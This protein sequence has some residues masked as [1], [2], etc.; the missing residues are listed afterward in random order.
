MLKKIN[1]LCYTSYRGGYMD[2]DIRVISTEEELKIFSDPYRL[3]IINVFQ[4]NSKPLTV[5]GCA[6]IM[7]EVP[8]KVYY[9][10]KKLLKIHILEL[11]H[12]EI[13]NGINAKY[14]KLI[15]RKFT[16]KLENTDQQNMYRQ[17]NHVQN[18]L[19]KVLDDFKEDIIK[20][21]QNAVDNHA[22]KDS[23]VGMLTG[24]H[25]YLTEEEYKKL[26]EA[27]IEIVNS[28]SD[29]GPNRRKYSFIGGI[30]RIVEEKKE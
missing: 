17:L 9:H 8:A 30:S 13:I 27:I 16:V 6:D 29:E 12:I 25:V 2:E 14:Y 19:V 23:D 21:T 24:T 4:A 22:E 20:S 26:H 7:G 10:V 5:K 18:L 1:R 28:N 11:D 15:K 3:K